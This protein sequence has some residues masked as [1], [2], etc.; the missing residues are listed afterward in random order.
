MKE[1]LASNINSQKFFKEAATDCLQS[2]HFVCVSNLDSGVQEV[3]KAPKCVLIVA[4]KLGDGI[5]A[6]ALAEKVHGQ[7]NV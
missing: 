7:D 6:Q 3:N 2:G 5:Y 1:Y 4:G